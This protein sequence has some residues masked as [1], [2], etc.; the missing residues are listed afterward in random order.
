MNIQRELE[1][2]RKIADERAELLL[3]AHADGRLTPSDQK[4]TKENLTFLSCSLPL[5]QVIEIKLESVEW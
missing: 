1:L 2:V 5:D 4:N 3:N